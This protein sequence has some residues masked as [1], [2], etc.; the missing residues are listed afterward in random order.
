MYATNFY[1]Y[2][3]DITLFD[4]ASQN[5]A[6]GQ[7]QRIEVVYNGNS[8]V[9]NVDYT[10]LNTIY[11]VALI[12]SIVPLINEND[13]LIINVYDNV[14]RSN[15]EE[16]ITMVIHPR[17]S[18]VEIGGTTGNG[19]SHTETANKSLVMATPLV[20]AQCDIITVNAHHNN[21]FQIGTTLTGTATAIKVNGQ[22]LTSSQIQFINN[23]SVP[24]LTVDAT[25]KIT[26]TGQGFVEF[27]SFATNALPLS[28]ETTVDNTPGGLDAFT[29]DGVGF[30]LI[31]DNAEGSYHKLTPAGGD[32]TVAKTN[33]TSTYKVEVTTTNY[34]LFVNGVQV[35]TVPRRV[36]YLS[37]RGTITP[38]SNLALGTVATMTA[39]TLGPGSIIADFGV[40]SSE[41]RITVVDTKPVISGGN[42]SVNCATT[43]IAGT[44]SK[45]TSGVVTLKTASNTIIA[46]TAI[47]ANGSWNLINLNLQPYGGQTLTIVGTSGSEQSCNSLEFVV[48]NQNCCTAIT[49]GGVQTAINTPW[50]VPYNKTITLTAGTLPVTL[51]NIIKPSW[52]NISI[53]GL[54]ITISGTAASTDVGSASYSFGA[55]NDCSTVNI[56]SSP[57]TVN[58]ITADAVD[59]FV[60]TKT[61]GTPQ[62]IDIKTND[63]LCSSGTTT[64]SLISGSQINVNN[65]N[66]PSTG[67]SSY[68]PIAAGPFSFRYNLLC[69]GVIVDTATVS[70]V[71][72]DA[73]QPIQITTQ[74][75]NVFTCDVTTTDLS[76]IATGNNIAYQWRKEGVNI[77][78]ATLSTYTATES[79]TYSVVTSNPCSTAT[80]D[81]MIVDFKLSPTGGNVAPAIISNPGISYS[82]TFTYG[83]TL[84]LLLTSVVKPTWL[85][86]II[87]GNTVTV[88]GTPQESDIGSAAFSY[89]VTNS[90]G[91]VTT[92]SNPGTVKAVCISP[93][94]G[95]IKGFDK[96]HKSAV[97]K[98]SIQDLQGTKPFTY[99]W[100]VTNGVIVGCSTCDEVSVM[101]TGC[102]MK[103]VLTVSNE[104]GTY[105]VAKD[106][107]IKPKFICNIP[108][109]IECGCIESVTGTI[110]GISEPN[111]VLTFTNTNITFETEYGIHTYEFT[112]KQKD[113]TNTLKIIKTVEG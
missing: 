38:N 73:C 66:V 56:S 72:E 3:R 49:G 53:N 71:A 99:K 112:I 78:S 25:G 74:T 82:K 55:V 9:E 21:I 108:I 43:F 54:V 60:G 30:T 98:Y 69:N 113:T 39:F 102:K 105:S 91:F 22:P 59:D 35:D 89:S 109:E 94:S 64:F 33:F 75:T 23:P 97:S 36:S 67:V 88:S 29:I 11:N 50:G 85:S 111:R 2:G 86:I 90:C 87:T 47:Q 6:P 4:V 42:N 44:I 20:L 80:S 27:S 106:I 48:Q 101:A 32:V 81:G 18:Y 107:T 8:L 12:R 46:T 84:P 93:S 79:G 51:S 15:L 62:T 83:G 68:T 45:F 110:M 26:N 52:L 5:F 76:V 61:V 28:I 95:T 63:I 41:Q 104:C 13:S 7:G 58:A 103:L 17:Y 92:V 10:I 96:V 40:F 100:E 16:S 65:V 77:P 1:E 37:N 24:N 57:G 14:S 19:I 34:N 70:G 31:G